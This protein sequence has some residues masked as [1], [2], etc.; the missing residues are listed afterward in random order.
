MKVLLDSN[1]VIYILTGKSVLDEPADE[2][3]IS[4][5]TEI[6]VFSYPDLSS[7]EEESL[8]AFLGQVNVVQLSAEVKTEAIRLRKRFRLRIPDA[9]IAGSALV[10]GAELW[11]NDAKLLK[12][13]NLQA[14]PLPLLGS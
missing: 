1:V 4:T 3:Y 10:I 6:E 7:S 12:I 8:R 11:T 13:P 2:Y 14:H 5:I 9:I